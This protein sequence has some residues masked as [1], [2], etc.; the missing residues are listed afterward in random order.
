[1]LPE[2]SSSSRTQHPESRRRDEPGARRILVGSVRGAAPRDQR[3]DRSRHTAIDGAPR[4]R[5]AS[6]AVRIGRSDVCRVAHALELLAPRRSVE[7]RRSVDPGQRQGHRALALPDHEGMYGSMEFARSAKE[8]GLRPITSLELTVQ[9]PSGTRH[10]VTLLA[11]TREDYSHLCRLSSR[12]LDFSRTRTTG[13]RRA[14][15]IRLCRSMPSHCT[16][17]G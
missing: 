13:V 15:S 3:R 2:R 10:H 5:S 17:A 12:A 7:H 8:A 9:E 16:P 6:A 4:P 1:M 11:E 14:A